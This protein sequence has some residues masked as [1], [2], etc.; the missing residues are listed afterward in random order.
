MRIVSLLLLAIMS[1]ALSGCFPIIAIGMGAGVAM[2]QDRRT[3][4]AFVEDEGIELKALD[5]IA[6]QY[7]ANVHAIVTSF[8]RNVLISGE[9]PTEAV[10]LEIG[11]LV[12]GIENVRNVNNELII[13]GVSSLTQRSSDSLITSDVKLRFLRDKRFSAE[14]IKVVTEGGTVYLMGIVRRAEA[15]AAT[16]VASTTGGVMRVVKLFEYLD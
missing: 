4:G 12:Y 9:V 5:R 14:H 10:K 16:E 1:G 8:N 3:S 2:S 7:P 13:A 11:K 15:T 6:K